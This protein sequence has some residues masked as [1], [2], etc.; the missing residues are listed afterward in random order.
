[1]ASLLAEVADVVVRLAG[2]LDVEAGVAGNG[3]GLAGLAGLPVFALDLVAAGSGHSLHDLG[4]A[5]VE[6]ERG[7]QD[8]AD[9]L[10]GTV[11]ELNGVGNTLAVEIDVGLG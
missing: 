2:H 3:K 10:L 5:G 4:D 9:R 6:G 7:G 11:G 1:M 8:D